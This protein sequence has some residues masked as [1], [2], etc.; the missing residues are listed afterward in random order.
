MLYNTKVLTT[1]LAHRQ[2]LQGAIGEGAV[3]RKMNVHPHSVHSNV[4]LHPESRDKP[5]KRQIIL[6]T[7]PLTAKVVTSFYFLFIAGLL[8]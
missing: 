1:E 7:I 8:R 5:S 4:I 3:T 6:S 2:S